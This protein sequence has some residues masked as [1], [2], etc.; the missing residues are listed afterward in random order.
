[1]ALTPTVN[2]TAMPA[3]VNGTA[4]P[5]EFPAAAVGKHRDSNDK[6]KAGE[7]VALARGFESRVVSADR[8]EANRKTFMTTPAVRNDIRIDRACSAAICEE[9][10]DRL[11]IELASEP[12]RLPQHVMM[13]VD[14]MAA[15]QRSVRTND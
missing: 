3:R 10:G 1:M 4:N 5:L 9:I 7:P 6:R 2:S 11:R 8:G 15:D 13:L 12:N 14:Q